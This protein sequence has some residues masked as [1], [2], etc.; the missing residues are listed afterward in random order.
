M[1]KRS[2]A[3]L[4]EVIRAAVGRDLAG[5]ND[6]ELLRR[7]ADG[8]R[9]AFAA[10]FRQHASMVLG[11]CRRTLPCV[12]DAEDA[13]QATF[14]L[15]SRKAG[16]IRWQ[17]SIANWLYL[18]ARRVAGNAR[19]SAAR[20]AR[21]QGR[22]AVPAVVQPV[23]RMTGR[24]L[25][26]ALE[27]ELDRLPSTYREALVLCYLEGLTRDEAAS[28]L[29][30]PPATVKI[31]LERGRKR[32]GDALT[33]RGCVAGAGLLALAATTPATATASHLVESILAAVAGQ[34][35][36]GVAAL[37]RGAGPT[38]LANKSVAALL[39]LAGTA[40]L[41]F[42]LVSTSQPAAAEQPPANQPA[43][44]ATMASS[45]AKPAAKPTAQANP[46]P[47]RPG[48]RLLAGRVVGPDGQPVVGA[49]LFVPKGFAAD[50]AVLVDGA[51][52]PV[53]S[54]GSDGRFAVS[55][56]MVPAELPTTYLIAYAPGFGLDWLQFRGPDDPALKGEQT[57]HL[58]KDEPIRGRVVNTE[59]KPL[60]GLTL[61]IVNVQ[62]PAKA[63]LDEFLTVWKRQ[64]QDA[65]ST[66]EKRLLDFPKDV[67]GPIIT[68]RDGRFV[69]HSMGA[70][71]IVTLLIAGGGIARSTPLVLTRSQFDPKP[72]NDLL[73]QRQYD[74]LRVLNHF[75]GLYAP[76]FTFI[77]QTGK[78]LTGVITNSTTG[79]PI[80]GCGVSALNWLRGRHPRTHGR[81]GAISPGRRA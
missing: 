49:K 3:V 4:G 37:A 50:S 54:A 42:G 71:R 52:H 11:V 28:R 38:R 17:P 15:L 69:V 68:D 41:G 34:V 16:F 60:A 57:L 36:Q 8:D 59:G 47:A 74:S 62:A 72:Y 29:G 67:R 27:I 61:S 1:T 23:D 43:P 35:P 63:K 80:A 66:L 46:P 6:R 51:L 44:A 73:L 7:Y 70:E 18:T 33:K 30:V 58:P 75:L 32:L 45:K 13:C 78:T 55:L 21:R 14:L 5:L 19:V 53:G 39:V 31:R 65:L 10:L 40:A 79:Q 22:A 64:I 81:A 9:G 12:Q 20:R 26:D 24:E 56:I 76:E 25:L 48:T 2:A 77:A